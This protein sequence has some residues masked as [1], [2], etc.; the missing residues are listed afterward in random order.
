MAEKLNKYF[1][2]SVQNL[3]IANYLEE[4]DIEITHNSENIDEIDKMISKYDNHPSILKIKENVVIKHLFEFT[5]MT[6]EDMSREI[7]QLDP[8]KVTCEN[9]MPINM[10]L[11]TKDIISGHLA[12]IYN[13]CKNNNFYPNSLKTADVTPIHKAKE[14]FLPKNYRPVSLI[15]TISKLFE[16]NM[17]N[18]ISSYIENSLSPYLFGYRKGHSTEQC[19]IVMI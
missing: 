2:Q 8:K 4:N 10:L 12:D 18:Q 16:R 3:E 13:N 17:F 15:P 9:D 7:Q 5:D 19:L 14:Q 11:K 6:T 1:I